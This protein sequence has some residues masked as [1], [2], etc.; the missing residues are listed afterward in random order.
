MIDQSPAVADISKSNIADFIQVVQCTNSDH[1]E[2]IENYSGIGKL[3]GNHYQWGD[4]VDKY[5]VQ[6]P[7]YDPIPPEKLESMYDQPKPRSSDQHMSLLKQIWEL[8]LPPPQ[9]KS[10]ESVV[11]RSAIYYSNDDDEQFS[12][13]KKLANFITTKSRSRY[14][15]P[16]LIDLIR[17]KTPRL[18]QVIMDAINANQLVRN[19]VQKITAPRRFNTQISVDLFINPE[20][21]GSTPLIPRLPTGYLLDSV[22]DG[23]PKMLMIYVRLNF[24]ETWNNIGEAKLWEFC[25]DLLKN[26]SHTLKDTLNVHRTKL[27]GI[28]ER[29]TLYS[30]SSSRT[31][32]RFIRQ[33]RFCAWSYWELCQRLGLWLSSTD[34]NFVSER[35][36]KMDHR[37]NVD[38]DSWNLE[39]DGSNG[40]N[41]NNNQQQQQ[42]RDHPDYKTNFYQSVVTYKAVNRPS[43]SFDINPD[44]FVVPLANYPVRKPYMI[45]NRETTK[46]VFELVGRIRQFMLKSE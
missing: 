20:H 13:I 24:Y 45:I 44:V 27:L 11:L 6:V 42:Q 33:P 17:N 28:Q 5:T 14:L 43:A 36:S 10:R 38:D 32:F 23:E 7:V 26:V 35:R 4:V 22:K 16:E 37:F 15:S 8:G 30:L 40:N 18:W 39:L 12:A 3:H 41:N 21:L 25:R 19:D 34:N 31:R 2:T 9:Y 1:P 29:D 46:D